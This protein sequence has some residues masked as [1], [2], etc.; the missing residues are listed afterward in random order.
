[1]DKIL[2]LDD[3]KLVGIGS[4]EHLLKVSPL[5]QEMVRL[6]TLER[7]EDEKGGDLDA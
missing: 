1:M 7:L 3:G 6:Q 5:Y 2:L 4:H